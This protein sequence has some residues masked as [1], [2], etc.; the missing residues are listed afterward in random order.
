MPKPTTTTVRDGLTSFVSSKVGLDYVWGGTT[1]A[2][3]DCSGLI[4]KAYESQGLSIPRVA[5]DQYNTST[6]VSTENLKPGDSVFFSDTGSTSNVTHTGMY[7]GN[8]QYIHAANRSDGIIVST[9]PTGGSYYVG[10]GTFAGTN[11]SNGTIVSGSTTPSGSANV[12]TYS[13]NL[14]AALNSI[15]V[16]GVYT[17]GSASG[18]SNSDSTGMV[19]N[20]DSIA[21][22]VMEQLS[23]KEKIQKIIGQILKFLTLLGFFVLAAI[24]FMKAFDIRK[25]AIM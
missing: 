15:G 21:N 12:P 14:K 17:S 3:Y 16:N 23:V 10:G 9:L 13:D 18:G 7:I 20:G 5:Q 22:M 6:K 19:W 25:P 8:G 1:D 2:G 4:Y 11:G 24:L